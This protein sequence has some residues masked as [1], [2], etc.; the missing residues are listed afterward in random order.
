MFQQQLLQ[1]GH[2]IHLQVLL[3]HLD[4]CNP[5]CSQSMRIYC[6]TRNRSITIWYIHQNSLSI[7]SFRSCHPCMVFPCRCCFVGCTCT[8]L[9][10]QLLQLGHRI[11]LLVQLGFSWSSG[12]CQSRS[13]LPS[14]HIHRI[15]ICHLSLGICLFPWSP[16]YRSCPTRFRWYSLPLKLGHR[17][18]QQVVVQHLDVCIPCCNQSKWNHSFFSCHIRSITIC[19][20]VHQTTLGISS[21]LACHPCMLPL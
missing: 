15:P 17:I 4:V 11:H 13:I 6:P 8:R 18:H 9:Q 2:R 14:S 1:L 10:W 20:N 5:C 12:L 3:R 21:F 7:S 16:S 19:P